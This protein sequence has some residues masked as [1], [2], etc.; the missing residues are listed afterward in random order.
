[1]YDSFIVDVVKRFNQTVF[2]FFSNTPLL[3][4]YLAA[5]VNIAKL[6][7]QPVGVTFEGSKIF[8]AVSTRFG[9]TFGI[10]KG[11]KKR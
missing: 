7:K 9:N 5:L 4:K 6:K 1:M 10:Q 8:W 2:A 11:C 3:F